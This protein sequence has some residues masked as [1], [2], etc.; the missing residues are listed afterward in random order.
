MRSL[1]A[2]SN[3]MLAILLAIFG[4]A[5]T[6]SSLWGAGSGTTQPAMP[7]RGAQT[8]Y[9]SVVNN[10]ISSP[11]PTSYQSAPIQGRYASNEEAA[12]IPENVQEAV[13]QTAAPM[14]APVGEQSGFPICAEEY[15]YLN[16]A[17][18]NQFVSD[19]APSGLLPTA[20]KRA[21]KFYFDGWISAGGTTNNQWPLSYSR[22]TSGDSGID[23]ATSDFGMNQ[24]YITVGREATKGCMWDYGVRAD[25]LYGTDYLPVSSLGL[26]SRDYGTRMYNQQLVEVPASTVYQA[27]THWN[28]NAKGGYPE[29]GLAMPQLYGEIYAP[30]LS[31]LTVK[32]GHFY[33]PL[34]Y[35]S[36]PSP[37]NFFYTHSYTMLYAEPQTVTGALA[38]LKLNHN[39]SLLAGF[40]EG[41]D[42]WED[43]NGAIDVMAG[44]KL[45]SC[46]K[47][48]SLAFML[49]SGDALVGHLIEEYPN[50]D[51]RGIESRT[52]TNYS[53]VFQHKFN[54][55]F[56]WVLQHDLG[57]AEDAAYEQ[58]N[59]VDSSYDAKWYSVIN[60][61]YWQMAPSLALGFRA[62]WFKDEG[63][64]RIWGGPS[65][66]IY[67]FGNQQFGYRM[68]GD[69]FVDLSLGLNWKPNDWL[70]L[71][72]EVRWDYSD[73]KMVGYG[74]V[75][76]SAGIYDHLT[77]DNIF[78]FGGDVLVRF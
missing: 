14:S 2:R 23:S 47:N 68:E 41:W 8:N 66:S 30:I 11:A 34:G 61:L 22:V 24:F 39:F 19:C 74:G 36:Y 17:A 5:S 9:S 27:D 71:R 43:N 69:N 45:E 63:Y 75:P 67:E 31:G 42:M 76:D 55:L 53:L 59:G 29:Y 54:P 70:T 13:P 26:E 64:S 50:G 15:P 72:P 48:T 57:V 33:S 21:G 51:F 44:A 40:S 58:F 78:T 12:P 49:M 73:V 46:D 4:S 6:V 7:Y 65:S 10:S 1:F 37:S 60:Y 25:L 32:G 35:E 62:E 38:D 18:A 20:M 28:R 77:K 52:Q 3:S 56:T 16:G